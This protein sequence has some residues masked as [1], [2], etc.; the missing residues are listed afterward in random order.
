MTVLQ[1]VQLMEKEVVEV[2]ENWLNQ[3]S[4][5]DYLNEPQE[6]EQEDG[7]YLDQK[8]TESLTIEDFNNLSEVH[9]IK[10]N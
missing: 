10:E 3:I 6:P 1:V 5:E 7:F 9:H 8:S 2:N 4:V